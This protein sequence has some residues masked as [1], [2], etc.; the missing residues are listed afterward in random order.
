MHGSWLLAE[1]VCNGVCQCCG[2]LLLEGWAWVVVTRCR[3]WKKPMSCGTVL[4]DLISTASLTLHWCQNWTGVMSLVSSQLMRWSCSWE[5]LMMADL[6]KCPSLPCACVHWLLQICCALSL[7]CI[8]YHILFRWHCNEVQYGL[9][10]HIFIRSAPVPS[11]LCILPTSA[12]SVSFL[13]AQTHTTYYY[14]TTT[15]YVLRRTTSE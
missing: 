13:H 9:L 14:F 3:L 6:L 10:H 5:C 12:N 15:T 11:S 2:E 7:R 1:C 4:C 8:L